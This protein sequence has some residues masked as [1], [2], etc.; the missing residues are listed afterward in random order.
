[1]PKSKVTTFTKVRIPTNTTVMDQAGGDDVAAEPQIPTPVR[2]VK[3]WT[4]CGKPAK[5]LTYM[6]NVYNP[7]IFKKE[8][9]ELQQMLAITAIGNTFDLESISTS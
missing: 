1:M 3:D 7:T 9:T 4:V 2:R 8:Q 6:N 5:G